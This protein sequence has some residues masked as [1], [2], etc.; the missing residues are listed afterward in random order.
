MTGG[1]CQGD[2]VTGGIC[3]GGFLWLDFFRGDFILEPWEWCVPIGPFG[4]VCNFKPKLAKG[5]GGRREAENNF[6]FRT[7]GREG[8]EHQRWV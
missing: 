6:E 2:F 3:R 8:T 5:K 4:L 1:F 7:V